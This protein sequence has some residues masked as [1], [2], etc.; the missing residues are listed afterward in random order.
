M[1]SSGAFGRRLAPFGG[2]GLVVPAE[3]KKIDGYEGRQEL[4]VRHRQR[5]AV[6]FPGAE[7]VPCDGLGL[8]ALQ[9]GVDDRPSGR[10]NA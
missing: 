6:L 10:S 7:D 3:A 4:H 9:D 8:V 2:V 5:A 1:N